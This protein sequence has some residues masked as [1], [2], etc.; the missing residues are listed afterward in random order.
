M[1]EN[2]A[3]KRTN[4]ETAV[5][6]NVLAKIESELTERQRYILKIISG[7][8]V[9]EKGEVSLNVPLNVPLNTKSLAE[10]LGLSRKTIQRELNWLQ[11]QGTICRVGSKKNGHWEIVK[12]NPNNN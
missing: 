9:A 8:S 4:G 5:P 11:E 2:V 6:L 10:Y 3:E 1:D 7:E 12:D